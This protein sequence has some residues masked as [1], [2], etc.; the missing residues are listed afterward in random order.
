MK[1]DMLIMKK[2]EF[3]SNFKYYPDILVEGLK[4]A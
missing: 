4:S 2:G 3:G 1:I